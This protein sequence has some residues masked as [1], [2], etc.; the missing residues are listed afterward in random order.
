MNAQGLRADPVFT[1]PFF[2][3]TREAFERAKSRVERSG[4]SGR[5]EAA[6]TA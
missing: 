6:R 2:N 5:Q 1:A 4:D 3:P